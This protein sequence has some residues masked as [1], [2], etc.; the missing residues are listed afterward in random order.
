MFDQQ[1]VTSFLVKCLWVIGG[2]AGGYLLA[3]IAGVGFDKVVVKAKSPELLHKWARIIGGVLAAMLVAFLVFPAGQGQGGGNVGG[4]E[5]GSTPGPTSTETAKAPPPSTE[6]LPEVPVEAVPVRVKIFASEAV[7]NRKTE[8][9]LYYEVGGKPTERVDLDGV[10]TAV[11]EQQRAN[12]PGVVIVY[13]FSPTASE[14]TAGYTD[15][16]DAAWRDMP[17]VSEDQFKQIR[18]K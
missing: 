7:L 3:W 14:R 1:Q 5:P 9:W 13:S 15:L 17:L 11:Q 16:R 10:H 8:T 4:I 6:K 12:K 18:K 2:F